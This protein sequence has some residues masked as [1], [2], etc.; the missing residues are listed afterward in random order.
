VGLFLASLLAIR[1][2][3]WGWAVLLAALSTAVKPI[4]VFVF[5]AIVLT[6]LRR[7]KWR[8]LVL[9]VSVAAGAAVLYAVPL[10]LLTGSPF[11]N[12][13]A[14]G[15]DWYQKLPLTVPFY[16]LVK[17]A[18]ASRE[19]LS[20]TLKL[21]GWVVAVVFVVV[22]YGLMRGRLRA[23]FAQNPEETVACLL[24][25][26]FQLSYNSKWAWA[27]FPRFIAP[28]LPF[29]LA[30]VGIEKLRPGWLLVAAPVFGLLG[31]EE[32]LGL[33]RLLQLFPRGLLGP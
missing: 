17:A 24:I 9:Y 29:L 20:N 10:V 31:A 21:G 18:L 5:A 8:S 13:S 30:Q 23:H 27:D 3:F 22:Y 4:G 28:I 11:G 1:R 16:P 14:Y 26:L 25:L 19:P 2:G 15:E 33:Q 7:K 12:F 6:T 32:I